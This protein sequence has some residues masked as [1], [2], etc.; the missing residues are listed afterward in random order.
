VTPETNR[1]T[2]LLNNM[3]VMAIFDWWIA[4]L[5][6]I[7]KNPDNPHPKRLDEILEA[8]LKNQRAQF[9]KIYVQVQSMATERQSDFHEYLQN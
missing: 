1:F 6:F 7:A 9:N 5:E 8:E 2:I 4:V 3:R